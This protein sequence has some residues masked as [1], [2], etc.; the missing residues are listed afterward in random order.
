LEEII[1]MN[2][3]YAAN[4]ADI[5]PDTLKAVVVEGK[6]LLLANVNGEIF[7]LQRF[8]PHMSADLTRGKIVGS[9]VVCP[10]HAAAFDLA[11]GKAV[12]KAKLLFWKL[13]TKAAETYK[14]KVENDRV[15]VE[16]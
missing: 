5:E 3:I 14:V 7:A 11:T 15:F 4:M 13:P 16:V 12:D 8:C 10:Q 9:T 1:A 6:K 2:Y